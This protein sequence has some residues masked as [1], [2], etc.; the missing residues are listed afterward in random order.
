MAP[1]SRVTKPAVEKR[2]TK[3]R[4]KPKSISAKLEKGLNQDFRQRRE[5][6]IYDDDIKLDMNDLQEV[7]GDLC[8]DYLK[9]IPLK[10]VSERASMALK[11]D[12]EISLNC[13]VGYFLWQHVFQNPS[14]KVLSDADWIEWLK[15][16]Q[17]GMKIEHDVYQY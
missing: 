17:S 2:A 14:W 7:V 16:R 11:R 9:D 3:L 6:I 4:P 8:R 10:F 15:A 1:T 13:S 5:S 12:R